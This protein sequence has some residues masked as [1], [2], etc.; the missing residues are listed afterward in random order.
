MPTV[1]RMQSEEDGIGPWFSRTEWSCHTHRRNSDPPPTPWYI[2]R[3][4]AHAAHE[5][6]VSVW[7]PDGPA[8]GFEL[9]AYDIPDEHITYIDQY[10][11][12]FPLEMLG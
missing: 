10:Q 7:F 3:Y 4:S 8:P 5:D 9:V 2:C 12:C 1:Y 11:V 6:T